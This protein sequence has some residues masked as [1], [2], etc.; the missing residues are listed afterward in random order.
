MELTDVMRTGQAPASHIG[1]GTSQ[2][3]TNAGFP[4]G[5]FKRSAQHLAYPTL[6][7]VSDQGP[8]LG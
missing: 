7:R 8:E 2:I 4:V 1:L 6:L 5:G 3:H